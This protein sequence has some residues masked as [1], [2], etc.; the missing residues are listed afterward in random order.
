[1]QLKWLQG[2]IFQEAV[3][4]NISLA[5]EM[6]HFLSMT[7]I[8]LA[9]VKIHSVKKHLPLKSPFS[10]KLEKKRKIMWQDMIES[11]NLKH[12]SK[13]TWALMRRLSNDPTTSTTYTNV[14]A[15]EVVQQALLNGRAMLTDNINC[16]LGKV[17]PRPLMNRSVPMN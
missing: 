2:K 14:T 4:S 11:T 13:R 10:K 8:D 9:L 6:L 7:S 3:S 1:M 12:S 5:C 15:N 16:Q 17:H